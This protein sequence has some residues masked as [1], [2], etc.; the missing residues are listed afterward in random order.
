MRDNRIRFFLRTTATIG[1]SYTRYLLFASTRDG[2]DSTRTQKP[3][4]AGRLGLS[5]AAFSAPQTT[6]TAGRKTKRP[7]LNTHRQSL[8]EV[9]FRSGGSSDPCFSPRVVPRITHRHAPK[10]HSP[11]LQGYRD[12]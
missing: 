6:T 1:Q 3:C 5:P 11:L 12:D 10:S 8:I 7:A 9:C 2:A 4:S